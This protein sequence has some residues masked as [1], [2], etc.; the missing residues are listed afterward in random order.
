MLWVH[1][2][3]VS[4]GNLSPGHRELGN[5]MAVSRAVGPLCPDFVWLQSPI[6]NTVTFVVTREGMKRR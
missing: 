5:L 2:Q 3:D 1:E 4:N 6:D